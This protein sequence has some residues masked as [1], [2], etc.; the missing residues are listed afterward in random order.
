[1]S[2]GCSEHFSL[3]RQYKSL[4][5]VNVYLGWMGGLSYAISGMSHAQELAG[6][7]PVIGG[8][9]KRLANRTRHHETAGSDTPVGP[10]LESDRSKRATI[11]AIARDQK[12]NQLARCDLTGF[13]IYEATGKLLAWGAEQAATGQINQSGALGPIEAVGL[14]ALR[15]YCA[16]IGF[17][18][19]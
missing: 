4:R 8:L 3:P 19:E 17:T 9:G 5:E 16:T 1:M 12:G 15:E 7:I 14:D 18:V 11:V 10:S 13:G 6:S 2:I